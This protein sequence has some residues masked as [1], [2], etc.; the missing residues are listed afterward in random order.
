MICYSRISTTNLASISTTVDSQESLLRFAPEVLKTYAD[1]EMK[2]PQYVL[3]DHSPNLFA[4]KQY[5]CV[6]SICSFFVG[7]LF[8]ISIK[9]NSIHLIHDDT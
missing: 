1:E 5:L 3:Y 9:T 7:S 2:Y 6:S 4:S 8:L